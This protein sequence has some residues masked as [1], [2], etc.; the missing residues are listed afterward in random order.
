MTRAA[1][2]AAAAFLCLAT[3]AR[4]AFT[5][6]W[7][8]VVVPPGLTPPAADRQGP[9]LA[10]LDTP[11]DGAHPAFAGS[12]L[13][14]PPVAVRDAHGTA[15]ASIAVAVWPGI[16]VMVVPLPEPVT[17]AASAEAIRQAVAARA[18]VI[19]MAYGS[20]A[21]CASEWV[22]SQFAIAADSLLVAA[23]GN[24][25]DPRQY[26]AAGEDVLAVGAVDLSG[27]SSADSAAGPHIDLAAPGVGLLAA[28]PAGFETDGTPDGYHAVSGTG[29]ATTI[30]AA[31]ATW[32][33]AARP[34]L[35]TDQ[36]ASLLRLTARDV[37]E[38][39]RDDETGW[40]E[41]RIQSAL[42]G[43]AP[44]ADHAEPN[45]NIAWIDGRLLAPAPR[46]WS[47]GPARALTARLRRHEDVVDVYSIRIPARRAARVT[48]T[49]RWGNANLSAYD[50]GTFSVAD[51][52]GL[53]AR[54]PRRSGTE[55]LIVDNARPRPRTILLA[56]RIDPSA[57]QDG[58]GYW[59]R[60][61]EH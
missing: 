1:I 45:D 26:P 23:A 40:G 22:Q 53:I 6:A 50:Q 7:R 30:V 42:V 52:T 21:I 14:A 48:L 5:P 28:A 49:P 11:V 9:L 20:S 18:S 44:V 57:A 51:T 43:T 12:N 47:G 41:P 32:L 46:V 36:V 2:A 38:P 54:A 55:E 4:A 60:V 35:A 8:S 16:R 61:A 3:S 56:I 37:E 27:R 31:L 24:G 34:E 39:G 58:A 19:S 33:R 13:V 59:L 25:R 10:V 17:C 29:A 15:M